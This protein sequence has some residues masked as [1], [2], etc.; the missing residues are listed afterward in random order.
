MTAGEITNTHPVLGRFWHP[1]VLSSEVCQ[2]PVAVRLAG[3]SWALARFGD[4]IAAFADACP[5][6][7][8]RLSA[9]QT[10]GGTLRCAY[11]GGSGCTARGR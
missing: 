10:T 6:R 11:H 7:R 8:A 1:A 9:G 4:G 5:H 3:Q 2:E